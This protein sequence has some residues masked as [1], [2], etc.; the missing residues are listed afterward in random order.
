MRSKKLD[1]A[2]AHGDEMRTR[3]DRERTILEELIQNGKDNKETW[4]KLV[5]LYLLRAKYSK[6]QPRVVGTINTSSLEQSIEAYIMGN[7]LY[8]NGD[9]EAAK[10]F[11][12]RNLL[13]YPQN[14]VARIDLGNMLFLQKKHEEAIDIL[15]AGTKISTDG[16]A[17]QFFSN[18]GMVQLHLGKT[19]AAR[20]SFTEAIRLDPSNAFASNNM[21]LA[22]EIEGELAEAEKWF[23]RA[24]SLDPTD[25]ETWYNLGN[26]AGKLGKKGERL[27]CF[28]QASNRGFEGLDEMIDGLL[29]QGIEPIKVDLEVK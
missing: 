13:E 14:V 26:V 11:F 27:F 24:V 1:R 25:G 28:V 7:E 17:S 19:E 6:E 15:S 3:I 4:A 23:T 5:D 10:E 16:D 20:G 9:F 22:H 18:L 8:R 12:E 21:G 29:D 2:P